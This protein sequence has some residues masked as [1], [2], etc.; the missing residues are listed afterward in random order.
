MITPSI[1]HHPHFV[2][3]LN[4]H[5]RA[6]NANQDLGSSKQPLCLAMWYGTMVCHSIAAVKAHSPVETFIILVAAF[7]L[8]YLIAGIDSQENIATSMKVK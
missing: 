5:D 3:N 2:S 6:V 7:P 8:L 4:V 1:E